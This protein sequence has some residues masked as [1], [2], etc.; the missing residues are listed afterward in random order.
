[1]VAS[2]SIAAIEVCIPHGPKASFVLL[3]A[4]LVE[5]NIDGLEVVVPTNSSGGALSSSLALSSDEVR[6]GLRDEYAEAVVRGVSTMAESGGLPTRMTLCYRWA[7]H[8]TVGT[9]AWIVEKVSGLVVELLMLPTG[10]PLEKVIDRL[11]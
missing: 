4:E 6:V 2:H 7:A 9:S 11:G 8:G 1:M 3:G 5:S 10:V